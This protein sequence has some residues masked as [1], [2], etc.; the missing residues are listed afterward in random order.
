MSDL[1]TPLSSEY[2]VPKNKDIGATLR[3]D[4]DEPC[5]YL[6]GNSLGLASHRSNARV[7]DEMSA[8]TTR[9]VV[10]H[11]HHPLQRPWTAYQNN[12]HPFLAELV[13]ASE[14]EVA[15]M[16]TLTTNLHLMMKSFYKPT[17]T[18]FK[19]LCEARA[20][21]SDQYAFA[22]QAK[23]HGFNPADA[24]LEVWPREG[25]YTLREEDILGILE[26]EGSKIALVLFSGIQYYTGQ[27]FPMQTITRRAKELGGMC[28]WDLAH[29]VG[30]VPL[31]LH[32]W[33]VDF[34]VFCTYK[35]LN[36]SPGG[37]GG[38]F[39]HSKWHEEEKP[40]L[41]GWW[42]HELA[43][44][45]DMPS[46]FRPSPGASGF[47]QST[48]C[49]LAMACLLGSLE[50]F[51]EAGMIP[52]IRE[53]SLQLTGNFETLLKKSKFFVPFSEA[54]KVT[55][56]SFT[57]ITPEDPA[58][59]GAQLSLL[60]LPTSDTQLMQR[61]FDGLVTYGV[62]GDEREP[63]VIRLAPAPLY[64]TMHDVE[65]AVKYLDLVMETM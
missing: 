34:A 18:R 49:I 56:P 44:R 27:H 63:G 37:I 64:N 51:K 32:D 65:N 35:Y 13:G 4:Q 42:G 45:F 10:G 29:A 2:L 12:L 24:V 25:E 40:R 54:T 7:Q 48:P 23:A 33:N 6:C 59:R 1:Y 43:T 30:N 16:S 22:S 61:V 3:E 60:F 62:I 41:A 9:G 50:T 46:D 26:K 55:K 28:G 58:S 53:R 8:W 47:Q 15:C 19:I 11:F 14:S 39:I 36:S 57:I 52:A 20:F 31:S 5:T 17:Q 21:P 38:L